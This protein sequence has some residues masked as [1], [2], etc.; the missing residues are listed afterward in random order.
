MQPASAVELSGQLTSLGIQTRDS[1]LKQGVSDLSRLRLKLED[2]REGFSWQ[3]SYDNELLWGAQVRDP[4]FAALSTVPD[5]T[6]MDA[7][8]TVQQSASLYWRHTLYRGWLQYEN[9]A[10][11]LTLGRLRIA[12][13]SGRIWNPTDRFN[14]V[15]PTALEPD[16]KLGVDALDMQWRYSHSGSIQAV[17]APGRAANRTSRK[18]ALRW[19][20][21][22]AEADVAALIAKI[23]RERVFGLD[24]TGN[25]GDAGAR[26]EWMQSAG[27]VHGAFGQLVAGMDYTFQNEMFPEGLYLAIEYF[28]NG[29]PVPLAAASLNGSDLLQSSS[30]QLLGFLAG[31]D[32]SALWRF[33]LI[34][35][36][37]LEKKGWFA[38]PQLTWS[39]K[40][41]LDLS[42]FYQAAAG[43]PGNA[44]A[45]LNDLL[46]VR[47]DWYF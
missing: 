34:V 18:L 13:G 17:G 6:W 45:M 1:Q 10:L 5:P 41:N 36:S 22:F 21:T 24:I 43:S 26:L 32:L 11:R 8:A 33:D 39:A 27:G 29:A 16:Q 20:D 44:F 38:S 28:Y 25:I 4:G 9:E 14:P 42:V 2:R 46:A 3:L 40:E 37:D 12:W 47:L 23:G 15:L 19:Q 31:Y 35:L 7:T 30:G